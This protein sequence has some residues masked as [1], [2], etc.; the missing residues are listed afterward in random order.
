MPNHSITIEPSNSQ[1]YT[2]KLEIGTQILVTHMYIVAVFIKR[3]KQPKCP[4]TAEWIN[5]GIYIK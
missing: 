5:C 2:P 4:S 3:G 1:V